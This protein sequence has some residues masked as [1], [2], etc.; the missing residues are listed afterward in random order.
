MAT[1]PTSTPSTSR[2]FSVVERNWLGMNSDS[3]RQGLK[4]GQFS[5]LT[6]L[7]PLAPGDLAVVPGKNSVASVSG[8]TINS[9]D[10]ATIN[11]VSYLLVATSLGNAYAYNIGSYTKYTMKT[12]IGTSGVTFSPFQNEYVLILDGTNMYYWNGSS[13]TTVTVPW[14]NAAQ[15]IAYWGGRVWVASG[16]TVFFSAP[17]SVT[18][19]TVAD[20]GG[21]FIVSDSYLEGTVKAFVPSQDYMYIVGLGGVLI[22][23]NIQLLS[24][25]TTYFQVTNA[26]QVSGVIS[27][28]GATPYAASMLLANAHGVQAFYGVTYKELSGDMD[29]FFSNVDF[30]KTISVAVGTIYNQ[31]C[32]LTLCYYT[33][34]KKWYIVGLSN[35]KWFTVDMG[36]LSLLSWVTI[37][38]APA[39]F[40]TDGTNIYELFVNNTS[41]L[42]IKMETAFTDGGDPTSIKEAQKF[43]VEV[44]I[45]NSASAISGTSMSFTADSENGSNPSQSF[46]LSPGYNWLRQSMSQY[47]QYIGITLTGTVQSGTVIEGYMAQFKRSVPW[48]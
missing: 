17:N 15:A 23:S 3:A 36:T 44:N 43:G 38:A 13:S 31:L 32:F 46:N 25:N 28:N 10:T 27:V 20:G 1:M 48:P 24:N 33:P 6:N 4:P 2:I 26:S 12:G 21:S 7:I 47:G 41:N 18:D 16:L 30:T 8:E 34:D 29:I 37:N 14:S 39:A 5:W 45:A 42:S 40:A 22:V 35:G 11:G 19:W 9:F